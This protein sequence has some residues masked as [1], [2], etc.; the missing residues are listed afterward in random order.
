MSTYYEKNG[1]IY[2]S[3]KGKPYD[4][5]FQYGKNAAKYMDNVFKTI[6]FICIEDYGR[7][8]DYFVGLSNKYLFKTVKTQFAE[9]YDEI[10]GFVEGC[11]KMGFETTI[12]EMVAWNNYISLTE[13]IYPHEGEESSTSSE[14]GG[15]G[16]AYQ[17]LSGRGGKDKC[18]TIIAC[19]DYTTDG[20]IVLTHSNF[21]N[22]VD[23]QFANVVIDIL[24]E[25]GNRILMEGFI[26]WIWSGTDF[27]VTS[28]GIVGAES[29]L[30][31]FDKFKNRYPICCRI[32]KAMQYGN[33]LDDYVKILT[34]ENSGDYANAWYLGDINTNEIMML[35]LGLKYVNVQRTTNGYFV[36]FNAAI[37]PRIRNL[38][39]SN[40]GY[41]DIRRHQGSRKVRLNDIV[42]EYKGKIN[43]HTIQKIIADHYDVYLKKNNPCSRT[44]CAHYEL[45][46]REY[47]CQ[48][49]RPEPYQPR[50][51]VDGCAI[52]SNMAR[53][54][55]FVCRWGN[56]CGIPFIVKDFCN[57]NRQWKHLEPYLNDR[58]TQPWTEFS[59]NSDK[60]DNQSENS[61]SG[62]S[63]TSKSRTDI[64]ESK[65]RTRK[66]SKR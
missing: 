21:S 5:G 58:P 45:D 35:E 25:K 56:S 4:R 60:I 31:G 1:W 20:K 64:T 15:K 53:N 29:T 7:E 17:R 28:K 27:F 46:A 8:W 14:G 63:R 65:K 32:R 66:N 6:R 50:G 34:T 57:K 36:G 2:F 19:G 33:T 10:R 47:M 43:I 51:A 49:G 59:I 18:S 11:Q 39:C 41:Y 55:S 44:I 24:P 61:K 40:T 12:Q 54:M 3:I 52:D 48:E 30:G 22:F 26:G 42:E 16:K 13:Y 62:K 23:G 9:F 38:E 37:D